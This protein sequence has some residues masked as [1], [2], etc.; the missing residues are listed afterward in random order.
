MELLTLPVVL[1]R[2]LALFFDFTNGFHD[3]ANAMATPI[4]TGALKPKTAV[5][6]AAI[7]N[8]I[9]ALLSTEVAKTVS[10]G[11]LHEDRISGD[12]FPFVIFAGLIGAIFWNML[13][14][15]LGLPSSSSH[16]LFGGLLGAAIVGI[17]FSAVNVA[18][19]LSKIILPALLSPLTAALIA[20]LCTKIAYRMTRRY[21][22]K[23]NGRDGFRRGQIFTSSLVALA[24]GTNDAQ[25]TMGVITLVLIT[26]GWQSAAHHEPQLWV[27]LSCAITIALGTYMGGWR[28]IRTLGKGLT[29]VRP[30]QGFAAETSTGA[31][32]LVSSALGFA[33]STTQVAS[34]SVIG[35]GLGRRGS[36][37]QWSTAGKIVSGWLLTLPAAGL[38]G[39]LA[40]V[41]IMLIGPWGLLIDTAVF[42]GVVLWLYIRSLAHRVDHANAFS[43]VAE[44]GRA[45]DIK[46]KRSAAAG[47]DADESAGTTIDTPDDAREGN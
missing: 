3:T 44:S 25:K 40:T 28:I 30:A 31:T 1:V 7:L 2:A 34:G 15:L 5:A 4:A 47:S 21:D 19:V 8:L 33:L 6:L 14:W 27:V 11:I 18:G 16:A 39:A 32:I 42:G 45:V 41:V 13:T 20:F 24:H 29:E 12:I 23:P 43:D 10:G 9:G 26:A 36:K 37:V 22:G 38:V 17:G 46:A 35:S